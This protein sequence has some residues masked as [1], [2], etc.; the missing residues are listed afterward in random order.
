MN[1]NDVSYRFW[2]SQT[3]VVPFSFLLRLIDSW[4]SRW[5]LSRTPSLGGAV[6]PPERWLWH[7]GTMAL[8]LAG[9]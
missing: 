8:V 1:V 9:G 4:T 2:V 3:L 5:D 7:Y 6:Q